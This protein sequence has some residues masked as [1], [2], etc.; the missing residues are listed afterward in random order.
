[1]QST[2]SSVSRSASTTCASQTQPAR[3]SAVDTASWSRASQPRASQA[4]ST[5][6]PNF[7]RV[8]LGS[9]R[10]S[11]GSIRSKWQVTLVGRSSSI[12]PSCSDLAPPPSP[13]GQD[14]T[15]QRRDCCRGVVCQATWPQQE[16]LPQ[17]L[18]IHAPPHATHHRPAPPVQ[19]PSRAAGAQKKGVAGTKTGNGWT[20]RG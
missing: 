18:L 14:R 1:M 8:E 9:R 3:S 17:P 2:W 15:G 19:R 16:P 4:W 5:V 10:V 7:D 11:L 12:S 20:G 6:S 13:A